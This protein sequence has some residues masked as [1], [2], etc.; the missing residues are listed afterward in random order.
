MRQ[1]VA[2]SLCLSQITDM[3][4][5]IRFHPPNSWSIQ[6]SEWQFVTSLFIESVFIGEPFGI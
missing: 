5:S 3:A 6:S 2:D 4:K 1:I